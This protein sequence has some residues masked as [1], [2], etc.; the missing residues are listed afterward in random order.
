MCRY[1]YF[2]RLGNKDQKLFADWCITH[3]KVAIGYDHESNIADYREIAEIFT[4][5]DM[6]P[7]DDEVKKDWKKGW[8]KY[9]HS[10]SD[11]AITALRRFALASEND[12]FCT[13]HNGLFYW[14]KPGKYDIG[15]SFSVKLDKDRVSHFRLRE[16]KWKSADL[17]GNPVLEGE[18]SGILG[19]VRMMQA[20]LSK[21]SDEGDD[22]EFTQKAVFIST[23]KGTIKDCVNDLFGLACKPCLLG[24]DVIELEKYIGKLIRNLSPAAFEAFVDIIYTSGGYRRCSTLGSNQIAYD[25]EYIKPDGNGTM[26]VQVKSEINQ[27]ALNKVMLELD[28]RLPPSSKCMIV[29]HNGPMKNKLTPYHIGQNVEYSVYDFDKNEHKDTRTMKVGFGI[30]GLDTLQKLARDNSVALLFL[31]TSMVGHKYTN[32]ELKELIVNTDKRKD[33]SGINPVVVD[34]LQNL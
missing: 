4:V 7:E 18:V 6:D 22:K 20:T 29:H 15:E 27:S 12:Y 5:H 26:F 32:Y 30:L 1:V 34:A 2:I 16:I 21:L 19:K 3:N 8:K 24:N 11:N 23:I 14:G 28:E 10:L 13:F 25:M 33:L 9:N 17:K 31:I